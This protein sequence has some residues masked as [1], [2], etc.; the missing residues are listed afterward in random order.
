MNLLLDIGNSRIKWAVQE[1]EHW[2][3]G[4]PFVHKGQAFKPIVEGAWKQLEKPERV[5]IANVAG[6]AIEKKLTAWIKRTWKLV[7]DY[8]R[9]GPAVCGVTNAYSKPEC[10]G[11]DR[12]AGLIAARTHYP[13]T[14][15][16][17]D[18]GTAIT[19]DVLSAG[20]KHLG[21]LIVPGVDMMA[22]ALTQN[23]AG[24]VLGELESRDVSLLGSS[25]DSAVSG[26]VLYAA[27][28]FVDRVFSDLQA[29]FDE[30]ITLLVSGGDAK[31]IMP[32]LSHRPRYDEHLV[33]RG[34]AVYAEETVGCVT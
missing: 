28:A 9:P 1:Q 21:G 3:Y 15:M 8:L 11:A 34:L 12:W 16:M 5:I 10:L 14:V 27:V 19:V 31:R 17:V 7:P 18:C 6:Q 29:E 26:G 30:R 22:A 24:I 20:G 13:G 2:S 4:E 32:L 25:T 23:T 33:L